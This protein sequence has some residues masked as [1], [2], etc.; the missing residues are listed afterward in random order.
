MIKNIKLK[1]NITESDYDT[2]KTQPSFIRLTQDAV[3]LDCYCLKPT[4]EH[5]AELAFILFT[6]NDGDYSNMIRADFNNSGIRFRVRIDGVETSK[7]LSW[8]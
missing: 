1:S 3:G 2:M 7:T 8:N 4:Q 5:S 6:K